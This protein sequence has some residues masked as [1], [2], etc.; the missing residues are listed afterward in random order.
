MT[1][2]GDTY[3]LVYDQVGSLRVVADASGN[4]VKE[5][6]YDSFGNIINDSSPFFEKGVKYLPITLFEKMVRSNLLLTVLL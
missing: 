4:L 2:D 5:V 3:Y 1:K 6:D